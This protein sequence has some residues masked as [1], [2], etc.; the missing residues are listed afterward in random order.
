M[1]ALLL[2]FG[3]VTWCALLVPRSGAQRSI[4]PSTMARPAATASPGGCGATASPK[5]DKD[6]KNSKDGKSDT[7]GKVEQQAASS[8]V[9]QC[10]EDLTLA[11]VNAKVTAYRNFPLSGNPA[12]TH[13]IVVVHGA[14]RNPV[15][16]FTGMMQ[17]ARKV[18]AAANTMVVS[19]WF[20]TSQDKPSSGEA[21]WSEDGWKDGGAAEKPAGLSSFTVMDEIVTTLADKQRFP[22][23]TWITL[24]G[25]SA[26]GQFMQR[27]AVFGKAP[28]RVG[29]VAFNFI[30][31]NPS[32][33][34]YFTPDRPT[35]QGGFS[36]PQGGKC[37]DYN[38]YK[39]GMAKRT[40]YIAEADPRQ[41]LATY[42]HRR[43][44]I[45]N[46]GSDTFDNGDLDTRCAA[47]A[48]GPNRATRGANWQRYMRLLAPGA[49][50]DR[51][52][53]PGVDHNHY[54]MFESPL[55]TPV[56]FG[57]QAQQHAAGASI[58]QP[59]D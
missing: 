35:A 38:D 27:Y 13:A 29:G 48:Q 21:T 52:V 26:G 54:A 45:L 2:A 3:V 53:V 30:S 34:V 11:S 33:Y 15:S 41:A 23:L 40:G 57:P 9:S 8:S 5:D 36:P 46:G 14:G 56:L 28:S 22:R 19:P 59:A 16:T 20:K 10:S 31:A 55:V 49:P 4:T 12:V 47:M 44:S 32:S 51:I 17:A 7:G 58:P 6:S 50:H 43:V 25:H 18:G 39:Y 1:F 24:A 42:A 37:P